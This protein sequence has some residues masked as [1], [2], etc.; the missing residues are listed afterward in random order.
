MRAIG[1]RHT[2]I[3]VSDMEKVLPFYRDQLGL[4]IWADFKDSSDYVQ[5]VTGVGGAHIWTINLKTPD[6]ATLQLQQYLSHRQDPPAPN[7]GYNTGLN[8]IAVQVDDL[9]AVCERLRSQ[10]VSMHSPPTVSFRGTAKVACCR[11]PEGVMVELVEILGSRQAG[12]RSRQ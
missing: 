12:Q 10:G 11:D 9:E 8:H 7:Y 5:S 6:G 2:A 1:I 4:E 3:V